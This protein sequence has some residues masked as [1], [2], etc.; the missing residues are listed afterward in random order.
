MTV[1]R[2]ITN[3]TYNE[4]DQLLTAGGT[5]FAYDARGNLAQAS[6][7]SAITAYSSD[8]RD[9][10]AGVT[11]PRGTALAYA[12]DADSRRVRQVVGGA[13]TSYLWD[14]ASLYGDVVLDRR[15]R[16]GAGRLRPED[17]PGGRP[18]RYGTSQSR[19][20]MTTTSTG[21]SG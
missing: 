12:Y 10:L 6:S 14:E 17:P 5:T 11:L 9:R 1:D 15:E 21:A 20:R 13:E 16:H 19:P 18:A 2:V 3:Y 7:G 8:A 4:L